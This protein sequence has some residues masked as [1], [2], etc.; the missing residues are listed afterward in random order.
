MVIEAALTSSLQD[1]LALQLERYGN[2]QKKLCIPGR[3]IHGY[4][5]VSSPVREGATR[6]ELDLRRSM[7]NED[8]LS[9]KAFT[10]WRSQAGPVESCKKPSIALNELG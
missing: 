4:P 9:A 8:L 2:R 6:E 5:R 1:Q 7:T 3:F 10:T